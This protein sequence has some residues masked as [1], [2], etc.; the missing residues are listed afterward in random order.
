MRDYSKIQKFESIL[1]EFDKE[2]EGY[3]NR[4]RNILI[5]FNDGKE[6]YEFK[7]IDNK[8]VDLS[9]AFIPELK[10]VV[11]DIKCQQDSVA[12]IE[13]NANIL[14]EMTSCNKYGPGNEYG[15]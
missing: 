6:L 12:R 1:N 14:K 3:T 4:L 10:D 13:K 15:A 11:S 5:E 8:S 9:K 2:Q 7:S